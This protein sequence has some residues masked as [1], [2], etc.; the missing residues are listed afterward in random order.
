M[1]KERKNDA[2]LRR[3]LSGEEEKEIL[4]QDLN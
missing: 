1:L 4:F 3:E 2:E